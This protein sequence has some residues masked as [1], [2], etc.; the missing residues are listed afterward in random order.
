MS[1]APVRVLLV[2]DDEDFHVLIGDMLDEVPG[3]RYVV[4]WTACYDQAVTAIARDEHDVYL[5]DY[6]LEART[7]VDLLREPRLSQVRAP[8]IMLTGFDSGETD[9]AALDSGATD[10]LLKDEIRPA[11]LARSIRYAVAVKHSQDLLKRKVKAL[12]ESNH[13]LEQFAFIISHD[14]QEPL[15]MVKGYCDLLRRRYRGKLDRDAD[16]FIE[17]AADGAGRM[18]AM[19][20]DLLAYARLNSRAK[21]F[22]PVELEEVLRM[23]LANLQPAVEEAKARITH[24]RL[25]RLHGDAQQLMRLFQNLI[26]NAVKYRGKE[27]PRIHVSVQENEGTKITLGVQDNGIGMDMKVAERIFR[28]FTRLHEA[29][30]YPGTGIGLAICKKIVERHGGRIWVKSEP[31]QGSAFFVTLAQRPTEESREYRQRN[32]P[33][34][35]FSRLC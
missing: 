26:G 20:L 21:P 5:V 28:V 34:G 18:Q 29:G 8:F 11:L 22:G 27:P 9:R 12:A 32:E 7:G 13:E 1:E 19:I 33:E 4:D 16:T 31:G 35:F 17:F 30:E 14:L 23:A 3:E 2:D 25:P 15:R 10:Y 6:R 24:D